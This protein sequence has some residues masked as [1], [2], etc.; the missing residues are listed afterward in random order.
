MRWTLFT[1]VLV[2]S[3]L[4]GSHAAPKEESMADVPRCETRKDIDALSGK[5]VWL[6]GTY[7]PNDVRKR[8]TSPPK[9]SGHAVV[10]LSDGTHVLLEPMWSKAA[11]R[12]PEEHARHDGR[13]VEVLGTIHARSPA[14]AEPM[15]YITNPTL[16]PVE[17]LRLTE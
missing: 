15:A 10:V 16:S 17:S 1:L 11:I 6:V 3:V 4:T 12:G 8:R 14:P 5:R 13:R 7:Q 2:S 9:S